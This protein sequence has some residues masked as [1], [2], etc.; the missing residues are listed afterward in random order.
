MYITHADVVINVI[1]QKNKRFIHVRKK[2][3]QTKL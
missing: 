2:K 3:N 1:G